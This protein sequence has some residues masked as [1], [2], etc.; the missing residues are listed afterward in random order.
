MDASRSCPVHAYFILPE[1]PTFLLTGS[2]NPEQRLDL[3]YPGQL[4]AS[5]SCAGPAIPT[6][7]QNSKPTWPPTL[8]PDANLHVEWPCHNSL[9]EAYDISFP[10]PTV[11]SGAWNPAS[12]YD[13]YP[14]PAP[15]PMPPTAPSAPYTL[16][17][18]STQNTGALAPLVI[19]HQSPIGPVRVERAEKSF[20]SS[21]VVPYSSGPAR[22]SVAAPGSLEPP[23]HRRSSTYENAPHSRGPAARTSRSVH[24]KDWGKLAPGQVHVIISNAERVKFTSQ[25]TV[26]DFT[27][28]G[29]SAR[30]VQYA[31]RSAAYLS[32]DGYSISFSENGMPAPHIQQLFQKTA[33][34]DSGE[35]RVFE[36]Y[37]WRATK[38]CL[39]WPGL[40][41]HV[42][43]IEVRSEK[44]KM[45]RDELAVHVA[46]RIWET[47]QAVKK[48][49][50]AYSPSPGME[51]WD[52]RTLDIRRLRLVSV[53]YFRTVW[54]PVL[55]ID[56][57]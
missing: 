52:F 9:S 29:I 40:S 36:P 17:R 7:G 23:N 28:L 27:E 21:R 19:H 1:S 4:A 10:P 33:R 53:N 41:H 34:L 55:A 46:T 5:L 37:G 3:E 51:A 39:D 26:R 20:S 8:F 24:N 32:N 45:S 49:K 12:P 2:G 48:S 30:T 16:R 11:I 25:A 13:C 35:D 31:P 44:W 15:T 47:I 54:I 14:T 18:R 43:G 38:L 56:V 6:A 57:K 50:K 22:L 42:E